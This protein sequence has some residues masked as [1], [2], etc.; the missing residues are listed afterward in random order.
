MTDS[1]MTRA[2]A[3]EYIPQWGSYIRA[4]DP[5][6]IAYGYTP[7]ESAEVRDR[8]V[9][10]LRDECLP[11]AEAEGYSSDEYEYGDADMLNRAIKY[12]NS[13][14]YDGKAEFIIEICPHEP[15]ASICDMNG[16][17]VANDSDIAG[18]R[19]SGD[20]EEACL[21]VLNQRGVEFRIIARNAAGKYENR[22][23][24]DSEISATARAIYFDSDSDFDDIETAMTYLVWSA[25]CDCEGES[26]E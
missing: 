2:E 19:A 21:Y 20:V 17:S 14:R 13:V 25:A 10:Y 4:G 23:A 5:G 24:T 8:L 22:L 15:R 18:C 3:Q 16:E 7:P 9:S 1:P 6:A 26:V 11:L 12:L